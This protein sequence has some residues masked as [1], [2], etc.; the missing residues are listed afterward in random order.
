M[1]WIRSHRY[2][3]ALIAAAVLVVVGGVMAKN[4][5]GTVLE[6]GGVENVSV[7]Y[8]YYAPPIAESGGATKAAQENPQNLIQNA[9]G[10]TPFVLRFGSTARPKED[11]AVQ[12]APRV[13]PKIA[14]S[15]P[16]KTQ[17]PQLNYDY[18]SFFQM[19]SHILSPVD[20]RTTEQ[21]VLFDYGNEAGAIIKAFEN[22]HTD[23]V[24]TLKA[25]FDSRTDPSKAAGIPEIA[26]V[27][28]QLTAAS[29]GMNPT[30]S[31]ATAGANLQ[32]A[33]NDYAQLGI[34]IASLQNIPPQAETLNIKLAKG[35]ADVAQGLARLTK[36]ENDAQLLDAIQ[37]YNATADEFIKNYVALV[38]LFSA[39]G[40]KFGA[41]DPGAIFSFSMTGGL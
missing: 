18:A 41:N 17:S 2:T 38:Q 37:A 20:T 29:S 21:K 14:D 35:Y 1:Q 9:S 26:N 6:P 4:N 31:A 28:A 27:Y 39:Y 13:I 7:E 23:V 10:S 32:A 19:L 24:R 25:F 36:T 15:E 34:T 33:A 30:V 11:S 22:T 3:V 5:T 40:V 12:T 16:V 8:P